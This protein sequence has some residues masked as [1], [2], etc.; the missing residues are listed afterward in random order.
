MQSKR[1][2]KWLKPSCWTHIAFSLPWGRFLA[3]PVLLEEAV[4]ETAHSD[5][6]RS[7]EGEPESLDWVQEKKSVFFYIHIVCAVSFFV[8][9]QNF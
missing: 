3:G 6:R 4:A 5:S 9:V 7:A 2:E 1:K 8:C